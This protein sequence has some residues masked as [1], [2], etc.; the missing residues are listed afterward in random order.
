MARTNGTT[1]QRGYGGQHQKL[2]T[3][4]LPF[5][6]GQ[7]CGRCGQPMLPGQKLEL[8]HDDHDRTLYRG[9]AHARC[10]RA[11]GARKLNAMRR[12]KRYRRSRR[13]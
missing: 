12:M 5:A 11:A 3:A 4:L 10:N 2:R 13:W 1:A 8:D 7:P 6:Y 9:M